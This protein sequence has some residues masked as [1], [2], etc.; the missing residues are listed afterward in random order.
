MKVDICV[1]GAGIAGLIATSDSANGL[2]HGTIAGLLLTDLIC[3]RKNEWA[4]LYDP[5]RITPATPSK[6]SSAPTQRRR[7][8]RRLDEKRRE[9]LF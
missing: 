8:L 6:T 2:T 3:G 5:A 7:A 4:G 1:V 9:P